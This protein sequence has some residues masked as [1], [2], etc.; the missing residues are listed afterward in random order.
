MLVKEEFPKGN[1]ELLEVGSRV[2]EEVRVVPV[3]GQ[4][5]VR[6]PGDLVRVQKRGNG[7]RGWAHYLGPAGAR[8]LKGE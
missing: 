1:G 6:E 2:G 7:S 5:A 8:V 4:P 3:R